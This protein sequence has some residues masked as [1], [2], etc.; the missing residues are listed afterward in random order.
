[1]PSSDAAKNASVSD[2]LSSAAS[3]RAQLARRLS[4]SPP[5]KVA[6]AYAKLRPAPAKGERG[7]EGAQLRGKGAQA[8]G[9]AEGGAGVKS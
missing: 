3:M 1:M 5:S 6:T 2:I 8:G 7:S 4:P 9:V